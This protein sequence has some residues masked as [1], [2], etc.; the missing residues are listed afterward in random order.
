MQP[1]KTGPFVTATYEVPVESQ[2]E[3]LVALES[4]EATLRAEGLITEWPAVR[5]RS[6]G[7][8]RLILEV[9]QWTDDESFESAQSNPAVLAKWGGLEKL[10]ADGGFGL[11][12]FPEAQ[13][14]WAQYDAIE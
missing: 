5:M 12:R 13:E 9:F 8:E 7:N 6:R 4:A 1:T 14:F 2:T 10:W 3:F 11:A